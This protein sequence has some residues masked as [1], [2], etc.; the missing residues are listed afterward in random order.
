MTDVKEG[1]IRNEK[2]RQMF[3]DIP[4]IQNMIAAQQL[5]FLDKVVQGPYNAPTQCMLT[6]CCQHKWKIGHPYLHNK[7]II[8]QH[9]QLLFEQIPEVVIDDYRLVRDWF[10]KASHKQYWKQLINC[11]LNTSAPTPTRPTT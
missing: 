8:V 10:C 9:L 5:S 6:A 7:D 4:C 11:L 1:Q 2:V 3:Y